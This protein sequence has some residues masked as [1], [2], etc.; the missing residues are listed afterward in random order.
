MRRALVAMVVVVSLPG[1][2]VLLP[3]DEP[4]VTSSVALPA[5][6]LHGTVSVEEAIAARRTVR[7]FA[8]TPVSV[9]ALG[10]LLWAG[11]GI[12]E[13]SRGRRAAPSAGAL[14]PLELYAVSGAVAGV[15]TGVYRYDPVSHRLDRVRGGDPRAELVS[16]GGCQAWLG[17]APVL[18]V[19]TARFER[20]TV[21]YGE[22]GIRYV[23]MEVGHAA[24]NVVLEAIALGLVSGV[25]GAFGDE[26]V[27][28]VLGLPRDVAPLYLIAVGARP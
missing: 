4:A 22:R 9:E 14:Y 20:T 27:R 11:Q 12:T 16:R 25:A 19:V 13:P 1:A 7:G 24:E 17:K 6:R 26:A 10:Q 28:E 5:P 8:D 21:K 2:G 18:L 23:H 3:A 15:P